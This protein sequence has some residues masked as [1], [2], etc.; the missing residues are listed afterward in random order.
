MFDFIGGGLFGFI[1]SFLTGNSSTYEYLRDKYVRG[2]DEEFHG[3]VVW[4]IFLWVLTLVV[5]I[6]EPDA[7]SFGMLFGVLLNIYVFVQ[8]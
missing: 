4:G 1:C 5:V 3:V 6:F 8:D 2:L 7:K